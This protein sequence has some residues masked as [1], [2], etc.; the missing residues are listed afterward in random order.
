MAT[1]PPAGGRRQ[2]VYAYPPNAQPLTSAA[3]AHLP[4]DMARTEASWRLRHL[5]LCGLA[6]VILAETHG[7]PDE[8]LLARMAAIELVGRTLAA[9]AVRRG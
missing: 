3:L 4:P 5:D 7:R 2:D 8:F 9:E 6:D 1:I